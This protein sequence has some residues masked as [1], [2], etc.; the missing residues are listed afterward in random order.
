MVADLS[1]IRNLRKPSE[2]DIDKMVY[3]LVHACPTCDRYR[4]ALINIQNLL[5]FWACTED[6]EFDNITLEKDEAKAIFRILNS[7]LSEYS[8][9]DSNC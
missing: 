5:G 7:I 9:Y 4:Q 8:I 1:V 2:D 3:A 6:E